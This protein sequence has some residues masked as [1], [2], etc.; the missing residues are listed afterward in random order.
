MMSC[1]IVALKNTFVGLNSHRWFKKLRGEKNC[2]NL[3][4]KKDN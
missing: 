4:M 1:F 2:L 3:M